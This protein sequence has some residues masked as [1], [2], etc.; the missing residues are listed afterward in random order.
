MSCPM[1]ISAAL[2]LVS[3]LATDW[4]CCSVAGESELAPKG[5]W[6]LD[7]AG[8]AGRR[9]L[10]STLRVGSHFTHLRPT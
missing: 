9:P 4:P 5:D 6:K 8:F 1:P 3:R 2:V 7:I 10:P